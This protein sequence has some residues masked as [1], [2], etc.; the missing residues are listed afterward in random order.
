M[1]GGDVM[2]VIMAT[3]TTKVKKMDDNGRERICDECPWRAVTES[4]EKS[5]RA[6][7]K[8]GIGAVTAENE[9]Q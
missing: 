4:I 7:E 8:A 1:R 6:S 2:E 9:M 5:K 3:E